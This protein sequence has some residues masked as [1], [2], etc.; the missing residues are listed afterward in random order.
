MNRTEYD[1]VTAIN[2]SSL[3]HGRTS[4]PRMHA[5][6][7]GGL[8]QSDSDALA[9]GSMFHT[10]MQNGAG[11]ADKF[12]IRPEGIDRRTKDGKAQWAA[13]IESLPAGATI[14]ESASDVATIE[15]VNRMRASILS[16]PVAGMLATAA[17]AVEHAIVTDGRKGMID[18]LVMDETGK[19]LMVV[20]W[21][22]AQDASPDGF[23]R[24]CARYGYAQQAAWYV[25]LVKR[26]YGVAVPFT[27]IAVESSR[28]H[29]V[30]A[31]TL[32]QDQ[33]EAAHTCNERTVT[34]YREWAATCYMH[35]TG[36][37]I[38]SLLLPEWAVTS[39]MTIAADAVVET[40]F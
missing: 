37:T 1:T 16:H 24:A 17:G 14:V 33:L 28:P 31:Y 15:L 40:P 23:A 27:F 39:K 8:D 22:T 25:D 21:K 29:S 7:T 5:A 38:D 20:D 18:K 19:P 11:W 34:A 35:H 6:L 2:Y 36:T 26:A 9:L 4:L 32:M 10:A 3:K 30:G 13:W 12:C